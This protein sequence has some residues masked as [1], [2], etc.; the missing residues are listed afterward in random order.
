MMAQ[1]W[2]TPGTRRTGLDIM[3]NFPSVHFIGAFGNCESCSN[4]GPYLHHLPKVSLVIYFIISEWI[5]SADS[6]C[7]PVLCPIPSKISLSWSDTGDNG[8]SNYI[9]VSL[10]LGRVTKECHQMWP[11]PRNCRDT[12]GLVKVFQRNFGIFSSLTQLLSVTHLDNAGWLKSK[13]LP[14]LVLL[15]SS[16]LSS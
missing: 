11:R 14:V 6:Q 12:V 9:I 8:R 10:R 4:H 13:K 3:L 16:L 15:R 5:L 7:S 2:V 1:G